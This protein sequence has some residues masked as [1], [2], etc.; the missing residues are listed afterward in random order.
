M[1]VQAYFEEWS[2]LP[3]ETVRIAISTRHASVLATLERITRGPTKQDSGGV[4]R[5]FGAPIAGV[6][7]TVPGVE[8]PMAIGSYAELPLGG[9]FGPSFAL[10]FWFYSSVPGCDERQTL[11]TATSEGD[12]SFALAIRKSELFVSVQ[13]QSRA[14]GLSVQPLL[15]YSVV[16]SVDSRQTETDILVRIKRAKGL[17]GPT[18]VGSASSNF[19]SGV[20]R[21]DKLLLATRAVSP[22]G[23]A[24]DGFNGKIDS[25][26]F[27]NHAL[28]NEECAALHSGG[29]KD[30]SLAWSFAEDF[31]SRQ[32][33][34][35]A[36][37]APNGAIR[38][39]AERA[40]TGRN[41]TGL[42]D[43]FVAAPEQIR[44]NLLPLRRGPRCCVGV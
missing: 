29:R 19:D 20:P 25:P 28:S 8:Q 4:S 13:G 33:R 24:V 15:W 41:W 37:R 27:F 23:S 44:G 39:G 42:E 43:S 3:G 32:I 9:D 6:D 35:V 18:R 31:R 2:R 40:V 21:F 12:E 26:V 38:N 5:P 7:I 14:L 16:V 30:A 10:H 17:P 36:G 1:D 11:V 34:E 22:I